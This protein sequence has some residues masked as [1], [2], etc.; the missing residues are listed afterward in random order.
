MS[1]TCYPFEPG[2]LYEDS[3]AAPLHLAAVRDVA[4]L[5]TSIY[6]HVAHAG[7][8]TRPFEMTQQHLDGK[9][10]TI[11]HL[12]EVATNWPSAL[13]HLAYWRRNRHLM[14][15]IVL[16]SRLPDKRVSRRYFT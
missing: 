1:Y 7:S 2:V 8:I 13:R 14:G 10:R 4:V 5:Q 3:Y 9:V 12:D 6:A 16:A 15:L 11:V